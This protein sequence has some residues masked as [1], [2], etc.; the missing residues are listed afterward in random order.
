MES[1]SVSPQHCSLPFSGCC[2]EKLGALSNNSSVGVS[3]GS[4]LEDLN[5][6][7][8]LTVEHCAGL[9]SIIEI[10]IEHSKPNPVGRFVVRKSKKL[11]SLK[12]VS[13]NAPFKDEF[14]PFTRIRSLHRGR[15][16]LTFG[17][18]RPGGLPEHERQRHRGI[19]RAGNRPCSDFRDD[20]A[21]EG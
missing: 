1:S 14:F 8:N 16:W 10:L 4:S 13:R 18:N 15:F 3:F 5:S 2:E 11:T 9:L 17:N 7:S 19:D 6:P 12:H 20:C 21:P